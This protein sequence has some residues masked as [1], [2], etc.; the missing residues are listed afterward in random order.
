MK[1]T[2]GLNSDSLGAHVASWPMADEMGSALIRL[3]CEVLEDANPMYYDAAYAAATAAGGVVA[4]PTMLLSLCSIPAWT[5]SPGGGHPS[6]P[7]ALPDLPYLASLRV[8]DTYQAPVRPGDRPM[9]HCFQTDP[10]P[11]T[12][13]ERGRGRVI[14]RTHVLTNTDSRELARESMDILLFRDPLTGASPG[15]VSETAPDIPAL[16][17]R[18]PEAPPLCYEDVDIGDDVP[19]LRVPVTL[20]R[21][22]MWVAA[23]R[24]F[25]PGH[26]DRDFARTVAGGR[27]LFIGVHFFQGLLGRYLTDWAGPRAELRQLEIR[28]L[29]RAYPGDLVEIA[30]RVAQR[31]PRGEVVADIVVT[32]RPEGRRSHVASAVLR[33]PHRDAPASGTKAPW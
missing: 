1:P 15:A 13:T 5:P 29:D 20:R 14:T 30:G 27:D 12:V 25:S 22:V 32:V 24:D 16:V 21:C 7:A 17:R 11:E 19:P 8:V 23:S 3:W 31:G 4:P 18:D 33:L 28:T 2:F 6:G 26:Y 9:I 10:S